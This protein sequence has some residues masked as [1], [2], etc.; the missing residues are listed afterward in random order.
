MANANSNPD[1]LDVLDQ[2]HQLNIAQHAYRVLITGWLRGHIAEGS[3]L[4]PAEARALL[5]GIT[6]LAEPL[7]AKAVEIEHALGSV[8]R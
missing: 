7:Q 2:L 3:Q 1:V 5:S 8:R 4:A 6:A